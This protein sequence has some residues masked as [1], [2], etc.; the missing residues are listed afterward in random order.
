MS[1]GYILGGWVLRGGYV[2][3]VGIPREVGSNPPPARPLTPS[4]GYHTYDHQAGD[5]YPTGMRSYSV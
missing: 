2:C 5:T 1:K 3:G 4:D